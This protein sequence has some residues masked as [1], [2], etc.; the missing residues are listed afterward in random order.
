MDDAAADLRQHLSN[1][2]GVP[3]HLKQALH[4]WIESVEE[5]LGKKPA[6]TKKAN[7]TDEASETKTE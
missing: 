6:A 1:A 5:R 3:E 7:K 4:D 2:F